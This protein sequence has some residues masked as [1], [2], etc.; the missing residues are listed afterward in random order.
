MNFIY[1]ISGIAIAIGLFTLYA[2]NIEK[3]CDKQLEKKAFKKYDK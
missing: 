1:A 2:P 3:W